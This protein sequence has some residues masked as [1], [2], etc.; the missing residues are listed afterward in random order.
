MFDLKK[1]MDQSGSRRVLSRWLIRGVI[2]LNILVLICAISAAILL[3]QA[4]RAAARAKPEGR[5]TAANGA[6]AGKTGNGGKVFLQ[7]VASVISANPLAGPSLDGGDG[8]QTSTAFDPPVV[9]QGGTCIAGNVIDIYHMPRGAGWTVTV[10]KDEPNAQPIRQQVQ[11]DSTFNFGNPPLDK[12]TYWVELTLP[13]GWREFT[14]I[15]FKVTLN[16]VS[17]TCAQV[18]FKVEALACLEVHKYDQAQILG[19]MT[20]LPG[21]GMSITNG[22]TSQQGTTDGEGI[23]YFRNLP[24]DLWTITEENR[25]GWQP[26]SPYT[27]QISMDLISPLE[28]GSC[29]PVQFVNEQ[30]HNGCIDVR[31]VDSNG[32][33]IPGWTFTLTHKAGTRPGATVIS[34]ANG[35]AHVS[36]LQTG[37]W[38]V[39]EETR[40]DFK[41]ISPT[42]QTVNVSKPG[43]ACE[44]VTFQNEQTSCIEGYKI[45]HLDEGLF[46]WTIEATN[47]KT[48]EKLTAPTDINGYFR[49]GGVTLGTWTLTEKMQDGWTAVTPSS[50]SVNVDST[51]GCAIA[52]FK[53]RT[54]YACIDVYKRDAY[55]NSG[56]PGWTVTLQ[57]AYG[58]QAI[59]GVTDGTGW[60]R[61]NKLVPGEYNVSESMLD[62]WAPNGATSSRVNLEASGSC[63]VMTFYNHQTNMPYVD[64]APA[65]TNAACAQYYT[66]QRGDTLSGIARKFRVTV[67]QLRVLNNI[68]NPNLIHPNT[69]LCIPPDP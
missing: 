2:V 4:D 8:A 25:V 14:P 32:N 6:A 68:S 49:F 59:T 57:P 40:P 13:T 62:G 9:D 55:D 35:W 58:G 64:N 37:E 3:P 19:Q 65:P 29:V 10:T 12:G 18:R 7:Q 15:R 31:K 51:D 1:S 24:P 16:G 53:N 56:L 36:D 38:N 43:A 34:D 28:P 33:P 5:V 41:P 17:G 20:P 47:D 60:F 54:E 23:A 46:G 27:N 39:T 44:T 42:T 69:S 21:W 48:G 63:S 11:G 52:R 61:F 26:A 66:I 22:S 30:V 50:F 45:N 67:D